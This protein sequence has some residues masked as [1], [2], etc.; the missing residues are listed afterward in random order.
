MATIEERLQ[1]VRTL[2]DIVYLLTILFTNLNNQNKIYYDMFIN[3]TPMDVEL[4]RY[5]E[6]GELVTVTLANRAKDRIW[7][8]TGEGNPNGR[9]PARVGTIYLDEIN[10]NLY[11]KTGGSDDSV[12]QW[13]LLYSDSNFIEDENYLTPTGNGSRLQ[14]LNA[15]AITS[16]VLNVIRGG[17]GTQSITSGSLV[18]GHGQSPFTAFNRMDELSDLLE[19]MIGKIMWCPV[20]EITGRWLVCDGTVY[21]INERPELT[22]LFNKIGNKYGGNGTNTFRVPDLQERYIKGGIERVGEYVNGSVKKHSHELQGSTQVEDQH[23]HG[24]GTLD[25]VGRGPMWYSGASAKINEKQFT[26]VFSPTSVG[27]KTD[28]YPGPK[29]ANISSNDPAINF[30]LKNG[31]ITTTKT[32]SGEGHSHALAGSTKEN[33]TGTDSNEV[34]H[35]RMVPVMRY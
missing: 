9:V 31:W 34:D 7:I 27:A 29:D 20:D 28:T 30:T 24:P 11:A 4:E 21:N 18:Q 23:K 19:S 14:A 33:A 25:A 16:G 35:I 10:R 6:N 13:V 12:D 8:L 26:G 15:D 3:P 1:N 32:G 2:E 17:T 22:N 5:N